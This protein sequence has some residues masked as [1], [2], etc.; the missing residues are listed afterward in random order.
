[1]GKATASLIPAERIERSILLLRGQKVMLDKDLASLYG[2][3]TKTV[4]QAV[5]R[6][7]ERFPHDFMFQLTWE[8]TENWRSQSVIS[9]PSEDVVSRSQS[10]TLKRGQNPKYKP[11]AFT[12]QGVAM[13]S[14]VLRSPQAV[15]VN[16]E[17]MRAF[18]RLRAMLAS[19]ADL[20]RKLDALER[21]YD[22][23]FKVVFD[24]IRQLMTPPPPKNAEHGFHTLRKPARSKKR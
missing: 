22:A 24:A 17:I 12:E 13:L 8:E 14:S 10:V 23:Q 5:K 18:V 1:M 7:L 9:N 16:I 11:Y 6:N 15:A 19:H 2:V 4:N 21:K 3:E 20:A